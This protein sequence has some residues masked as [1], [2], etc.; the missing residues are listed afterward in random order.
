MSSEPAYRTDLRWFKRLSELSP[1]EQK[2]LL[3]LSNAKYNWRTRDRLLAVTG[4]NSDELDS[5][6]AGLIARG[7]IR[8]SFSKNKNIIFGLRE[9][10]DQGD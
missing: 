3:A 2:I 9:R 10:V 6:L 8:P 1:A 5:T 4:L 7:L